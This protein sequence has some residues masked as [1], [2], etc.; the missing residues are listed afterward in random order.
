M[1]AGDVNLSRAL[2]NVIAQYR[3]DRFGGP[4]NPMQTEFLRRG[5]LLA[6]KVSFAPQNAMF[7]Q[8]SGLEDPADLADVLDFYRATDQHCWVNVPPYSSADLTR[9]LIRAGF[10][11]QSSAAVMWAEPVPTAE[12]APVR[13]G[14]DVAWVERSDQ[15]VFLDTLNLGFGMPNTQLANVRRNQSF[16]RDVPG[17]HFCLARVN[18]EPAGA[19]VLSV[20]GE[21]GYLAA[22]ATLPAFRRRGVHAALIA[23]RITLARQLGLE[24]VAGQADFG[25]ASQRNQQRAGLAIAHTKSIW[26]NHA[27]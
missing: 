7:N 4:G 2:E 5:T 9:A 26:T 6:T 27:A 8:V 10:V 22:G 25:S 19:A 24:R 11:P 20:H 18:G 12:A 13:G 3:A 15:D 23:A 21:L 14:V 17:W 1:R 16:W